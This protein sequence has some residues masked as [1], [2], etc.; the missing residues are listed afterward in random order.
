M[1]DLYIS[2]SC[3][4]F[5]ESC[6]FWRYKSFCPIPWE[7]DFENFAQILKLR[8]LRPFA[9]VFYFKNR[10]QTFRFSI[11]KNWNNRFE[12][13]WWIYWTNMS[14]CIFIYFNFFGIEN[15]KVCFRW[16]EET[17]LF[18]IERPP[19]K[20][21]GKIYFLGLRIVAPYD[22]AVRQRF[23]HN[24]QIIWTVFYSLDCPSCACN[25]TLSWKRFKE[26][27]FYSCFAPQSGLVLRALW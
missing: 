14:S 22:S 23:Y 8:G 4:R 16:K 9:W 20:L 15:W 18:H 21:A 10:Y 19:K 6:W 27:I 25:N 2:K 11:P 13:T 17:Q 7:Y 1:T 24:V 26:W 5:S 3:I 12:N